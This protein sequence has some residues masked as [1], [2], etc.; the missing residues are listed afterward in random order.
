MIAQTKHLIGY[1]HHQTYLLYNSLTGLRFMTYVT[2]SHSLNNL[3]SSKIFDIR[4]IEA[5]VN[6]SKTLFP[7]LVNDIDCR[8]ES[9]YLSSSRPSQKCSQNTPPETSCSPPH[10]HPVEDNQPLPTLSHSPL[11]VL[12]KRTWSPLRWNA[13]F[14]IA[15]VISSPIIR[16]IRIQL[17]QLAMSNFR[18]MTALLDLSF[19][20]KL[21]SFDINSSSIS[22]YLYNSIAN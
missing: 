14:R 16:P 13:G 3:A 18:I 4:V 8:P 15:V 21:I 17:A 22:Y 12:S 11:I 9:R 6:L 20:T 2:V 1:V 5:I 19:L 10:C 7:M